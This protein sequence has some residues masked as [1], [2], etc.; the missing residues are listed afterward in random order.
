MLVYG[1]GQFFAPHQDSEKADGMVGTLVVTLPSGA[2]GGVLTVEHAGR[3][4][5][6]RA[7]KDVLSFVAFYADCRHDVRKS[8]Y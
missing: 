8:V 6:Y 3:T 2:K 7:S 1:P 5:S 4:E